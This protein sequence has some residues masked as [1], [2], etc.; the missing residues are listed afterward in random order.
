VHVLD[1]DSEEKLL[2]S[3]QPRQAVCPASPMYSPASHATQAVCPGA[4]W[5]APDGHGAQLGPTLELQAAVKK[6]PAPQSP[7]TQALHVV[8]PTSFW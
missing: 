2:P 4:A 1:P 5:N 7:A 8:L 3:T 6:L